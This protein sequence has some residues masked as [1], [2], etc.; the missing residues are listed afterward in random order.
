MTQY[1]AVRLDDYFV[2]RGW[3]GWTTYFTTMD[4]LCT[5]IAALK[6]FNRHPEVI[7]VFE[8][9]QAGAADIR[10][11]AGCADVRFADAAELI[12]ETVSEIG[13]TEYEFKNVYK[14]KQHFRISSGI[15]RQAVFF[16]DERYWH[17]I[18]VRLHDVQ[19]YNPFF[20]KWESIGEWFWGFPGMIQAHGSTLTNTLWMA[21][22]VYENPKEALAAL[23]QPDK[24]SLHSFWENISGN[25]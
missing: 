14:Y 19:R 4:D 11:Q 6:K 13:R 9:F 3:S 12:A 17:C 24:L 23:E 5:L 16:H 10:Y 1:F 8:K 2:P 25:G 20:E 7:E 22:S 15:I 21:E 18:K